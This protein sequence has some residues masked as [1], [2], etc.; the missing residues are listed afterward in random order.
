[1]GTPDLQ[2]ENE[3]LMSVL[4]AT[5]D[6]VL[7]LDEHLVIKKPAPKLNMML[8]LRGSDSLEGYSITNLLQA[9][10]AAK[11][12]Q[13]CVDKPFV[14]PSAD[15]AP[16]VAQ[17]FS[18]P[19]K[20]AQEGESMNVLFYHAP[21]RG[22]RGHLLGM[23]QVMDWIQDSA[24]EPISETELRSGSGPDASIPS[25]TTVG[26]SRGMDQMLNGSMSRQSSSHYPFSSQQMSPSG[27][28]RHPGSYDSGLGRTSS[29]GSTTRPWG[30]EVPAGGHPRGDTLRYVSGGS[31][32]VQRINSR[33]PHS[34]P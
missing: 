18:L 26:C 16:G 29:I 25:P 13:M 34:R 3:A 31:L 22:A 9:T 33:R 20:M 19:L 8:G 5:C 15:G 4:N 21:I 1:M 23:S 6:A 30:S 32:G 2:C 28:A 11:K 14:I 24:H 12:F 27:A 10:W 17:T 7:H